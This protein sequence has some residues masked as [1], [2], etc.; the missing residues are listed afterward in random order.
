MLLMFLLPFSLSLQCPS[1]SCKLS[2]QQFSMQQCIFSNSSSLWLNPCSNPLLSYCPPSSKNSTCLPPPVSNPAAASFPGEPCSQDSDC[3]AGMCYQSRCNSQTFMGQCTS[4]ADCNPGFYCNQ[5]Q[6][7]CLFQLEINQTGCSSDFDCVNGAGCNFNVCVPYL[8]LLAGSP[9]SQCTGN[10]NW[11]CGNLTCASFNGSFA[12]GGIVT[13]NTET[14]QKDSD[15]KSDLDPVLN[16]NY[17]SNCLC[18]YAK[19]PQTLCSLLPGDNMYQQYMSQMKMWVGNQLIRLCNTERRFSSQCISNYAGNR[20]Q[21]LLN[22][23][24]VQLYPMIDNN[25]DCTQEIFNQQYWSLK[26]NKTSFVIDK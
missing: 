13:R 1:Y 17:Y 24:Y 12:C 19:S 8:T 5:A 25:E 18:S 10:V 7:V 20:N 9:I 26:N 14:C 23:Y 16:V 22:R 4:N 11:L 15:C 21:L 6:S 2:S 3:V